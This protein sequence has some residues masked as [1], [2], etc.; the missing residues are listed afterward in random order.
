[1]V[2]R[3]PIWARPSGGGGGVLPSLPSSGGSRS[4]TPSFSNVSAGFAGWTENTMGS[5]AAAISPTSLPS[6]A[7]KSVFVN[8]SGVDK[9]TGEL[10]R[11]A[12]GA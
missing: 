7:G 8:L 12:G 5:L 11:V 9:A 4:F 10:K 6:M 2:A 1:M 3:R